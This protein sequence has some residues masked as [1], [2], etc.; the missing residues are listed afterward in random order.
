MPPNPYEP[1]T[2]EI[3]SGAMRAESPPVGVFLST[4]RATKQ[5]AR[6]GAIVGGA[7]SLLFI[8]PAVAL[9]AFGLGSSGVWTLPRFFFYGIGWFGLFAV[10]GG[11]VAGGLGWSAALIGKTIESRAVARKLAA[12]KLP[13]QASLDEAA[14]AAPREIAARSRRTTLWLW[15]TCAAILLVSLIVSVAGFA[16]GAIAGRS[17]DRRLDAAVA[18]ADRDDP[19]WRLDDLMDHREPVPAAENS[20][21]VVDHVVA[22]LPKGWLG[23]TKLQS[24]EKGTRRGQVKEDLGRLEETPPNRTLSDPVAA[25]L[26]AE[27]KTLGEAVTLARTLDRYLRGFHE[28]QIGPTISDTPLRQTQDTRIVARLLAM[29][30]AIQAHDGDLDGALGSCRAMLGVGRS[31]GDEPFLISA[32]VRCSLGAVT[33][34]SVRR[35]LGHGEPSEAALVRLQ[36]AVLDELSQ[37]LLVIPMRGER[38]AY[39]E[40]IRRVEEGEIPIS[41]LSGTAKPRL[42]VPRPAGSPWTKVWF[43]YQITLYLEWMNAAVAIAKR[44]AAEQPARWRAWQAN[45]DRVKN[46]RF[47]IYTA[48][49][50][51]LLS[52]P[53][54]AVAT[55]FSRHQSEL[56]ATAI[57]I[58]AEHHRRKNGR[59]PASIETIDPGILNSAPV[60]PYSGQPFR[61]EHRDGQ[62][63]IYSIGPNGKDEHGEYDP[64]RW[65]DGGKDD[66]GARAWDLSLRRRPL[67]PNEE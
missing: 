40:L 9:A 7:L 41:A 66:V 56:G 10:F 60:D 36:A 22:L 15:L 55:A 11:V 23:D 14:T 32:L 8:I 54:P 21:L 3:R 27:L 58:A 29:D 1:G 30:A 47:G 48:T 45:V 51:L 37:P 19:N 17:I 31:I 67:G 65:P 50:P 28:I 53:I 49:F 61:F 12:P 35:V 42:P 43:D 44:P 2:P 26:R 6:V 57:L 33:L 62:F 4:R 46:S 63:L 13:V 39:T 16:S 20:S 24:G 64:K 59:W 52:P 25:S 18:E 34:K 5:G 38:A